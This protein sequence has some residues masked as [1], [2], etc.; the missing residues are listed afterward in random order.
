MYKNLIMTLLPLILLTGCNE[1]PTPTYLMQHRDK[2]ERA[3]ENCQ[4][5]IDQKDDAYC[6]MV[7]QAVE[8]FNNLITEQQ[9]N[10]ELFG[11]KIMD[12][13][14]AC[15]KAKNDKNANADQLAKSCDQVEVMLA[16][17]GLSSPE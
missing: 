17:V 5:S 7:G 16:V 2:L 13:E 14:I 11:Q 12:Q 8:D 4:S 10:P 15:A 9:S 6:K 3:M 1:K